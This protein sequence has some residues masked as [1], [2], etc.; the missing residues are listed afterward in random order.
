MNIYVFAAVA[1]VAD[2][3]I[4]DVVAVVFVVLVAA[5][6]VVVVV[7]NDW[8]MG[9]DGKCFVIWLFDWLEVSYGFSIIYLS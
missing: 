1:A 3:A 8:R 9:T 4:A 5:V 7:V 6:F 2:V